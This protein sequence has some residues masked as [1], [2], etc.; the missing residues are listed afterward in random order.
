M[1]EVEKVY[2]VTSMYFYKNNSSG[3]KTKA[4]FSAVFLQN[5]PRSGITDRKAEKN[6]RNMT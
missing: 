2:N 5:M 1:K 3:V 6:L 4:R